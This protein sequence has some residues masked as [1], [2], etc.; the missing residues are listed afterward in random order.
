[1]EDP[2]QLRN[3][4]EQIVNSYESKVKTVT[5]LMREVHQRIKNYHVEQEEMTNRLKGILAKN[6]CLRKKDFDTMKEGIRNHKKTRKREVSQ[7]VEDFCNEEEETIAKLKEILTIKNP[8]TL[9]DFKILKEKMLTRPKEREKR[10][11]QMLK[12]FH[13]D[14][15]EVNT[16]LRVLLEKGPSV[17]I[18]DFKAMVKAFQIERKDENA[19]VDQ[20]LYEFEKIKDEISNQWQRVIATVG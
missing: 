4:V 17:R 1:M 2:K 5:S 12:D 16:A 8:S 3:I 7:M 20:I 15:E 6:E 14:Q 11:S 9:E 18:N 10:V 19:K 13:R